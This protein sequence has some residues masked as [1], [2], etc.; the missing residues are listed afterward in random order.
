MMAT[1]ESEISAAGLIARPLPFAYLLIPL[2]CVGGGEF[3]LFF[4][5]VSFLDS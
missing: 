2:R 3:I 1:K 4:I 5:L